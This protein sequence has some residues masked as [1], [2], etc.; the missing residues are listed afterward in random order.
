MIFP[1]GY[2]FLHLGISCSSVPVSCNV[3]NLVQ[4]YAYLP[5]LTKRVCACSSESENRRAGRDI[6]GLVVQPQ[7]PQNRKPY[8]LLD[9]CFPIFSRKSPAMGLSLAKKPTRA[10]DIEVPGWMKIQRLKKWETNIGFMRMESEACK[11]SQLVTHN[12]YKQRKTNH[13]IVDGKAFIS[14][15]FTAKIWTIEKEE[16]IF[17]AA[18]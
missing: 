3:I 18:T 15:Y 10:T 14:C 8:T 1:L 12:F 13:F 9:K 4:N 2:F 6:G 16:T 11:I 7:E 5:A 17:L